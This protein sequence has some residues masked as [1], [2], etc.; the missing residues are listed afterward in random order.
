[1]NLPELRTFLAIVDSGS[2]VRAS[3]TLHVT[4]STVTARLKSLED[5]LGQTLLVRN[6]SG[7]TM[8][9][10]GVKLHR[11][12]STIANLWQQ[13]RQ[14]VA[15]PTGASGFCNLACEYDLWPKLGQ[16]FM[17][18][19]MTMT[20]D[21]GVSVWLGSQSEVARWMLEGKSDLALTY[22]SAVTQQQGQII[23]SPDDL[24]LV[25]DT[26]DRPIRF[27]TGY[28]YVEAGETFGRDHAI[29]YADAGTARISFG[30]ATAGL[31]YLMR[32]GGSAYLPQRLVQQPL[33]DG[34]LFHLTQ[35]P[36]FQRNVYLTYDKTQRAH[37]DW[38]DP[39]LDQLQG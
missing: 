19:L 1:M 9:A 21:I 10:A 35:A 7:A 39:V 24:I 23:L 15:L 34:R 2:L 12:A 25:S 18:A 37:W 5:E 6:K 26:P 3:Q 38:L 28:I 29:A 32:T 17:H 8:T 4:Q 33:A 31:D 20:P 30:N 11:Y 16:D 14:D 36:T 13:A 27:S 22:R